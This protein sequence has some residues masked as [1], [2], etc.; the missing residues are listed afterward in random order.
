M[1]NAMNNEFL[2]ATGKIFK[3]SQ[4]SILPIPD[5]FPAVLSS[6]L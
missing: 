3:R 6:E 4:N 2:K 1:T 5:P